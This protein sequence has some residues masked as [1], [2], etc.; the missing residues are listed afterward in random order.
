VNEAAQKQSVLHASLG[1]RA[2]VEHYDSR[3][4]EIPAEEDRR[5]EAERPRAP[6]RQRER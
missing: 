1:E 5:E 6:A 3:Y 4:D 2:E